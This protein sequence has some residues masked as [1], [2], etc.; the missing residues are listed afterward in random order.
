METLFLSLLFLG[1]TETVIK[2]IIVN[3]FK[4][5]IKKYI[6]PAYDKLDKLLLIPSNW[7]HF[8]NDAEGFIRESIIPEELENANPKAKDALVSHLVNNFDLKS[9]LSKNL[10]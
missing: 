7:E 9:F 5:G 3:L 2:P 8:V 10:P 4:L 1:L 6:F